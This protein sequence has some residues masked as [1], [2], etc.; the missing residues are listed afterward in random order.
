MKTEIVKAQAATAY[1]QAM[2]RLRRGEVIAIPTDTV[3]GV[4]TD[5]FNPDAIDKLFAAKER[6]RDKPIPLLLADASD[7]RQVALHIPRGALVLAGRFWPGGLTLVVCA[8]EH[9]PPILRAGGDSV[10]VRVPNYPVP[11]DLA[12]ILGRPLAAT[13]ANISGGPNPS[14]AQ[15]VE[16]QLGGRIGLILDGGTVGA[17]LPSTVIDLTVTPPRVL[18]AG[19]L[20][21]VDIEAVL[22]QGISADVDRN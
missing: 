13:S 10:A 18:R 11:R 22:G 3:Y 1:D 4:A 17:G 5:G 8:C 14:T 9:V 16:Q 7:L 15:E 6:P 21:L 20:P 12:R 2:E 19:A